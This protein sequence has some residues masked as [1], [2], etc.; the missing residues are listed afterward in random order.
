[1]RDSPRRFFLVVPQVAFSMGGT[2]FELRPE[3]YVLRI[4]AGQQQECLSGF[5]G[6]DLPPQLANLWILGDVFLGAW[7]SVY[8]FANEK[9]GFA[10]SI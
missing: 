4:G 5:I 7:H 10:K 3:Q 1:M 8:D 2:S 6:L 9:V